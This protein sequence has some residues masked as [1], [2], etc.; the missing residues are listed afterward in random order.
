MKIVRAENSEQWERTNDKILEQIIVF[1]VPPIFFHIR[2]HLRKKREKRINKLQS[3]KTKG[4][5]GM[6]ILLRA[7]N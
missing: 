6:E 1:D 4:A 3:K 2:F 7:L 5:S